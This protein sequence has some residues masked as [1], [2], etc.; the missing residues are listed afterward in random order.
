MVNFLFG[1]LVHF[2]LHVGFILP[3]A[4]SLC[5]WAMAPAASGCLG[6]YHSV[7]LSSIFLSS[8]HSLNLKQ[9]SYHIMYLPLIQSLGQE[10]CVFRMA[11]WITCLS[12]VGG[13]EALIG[14]VDPLI[15]I[16]TLTKQRES[17]A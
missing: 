16:G 7:S 13:G 14:G 3:I 2:H 5:P 6:P 8:I 17:S 1:S 10:D 12:L 15:K 11:T 4:S 9:V